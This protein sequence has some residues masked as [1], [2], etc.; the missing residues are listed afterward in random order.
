MVLFVWNIADDFLILVSSK[1]QARYIFIIDIAWI[2]LGTRVIFLFLKDNINNKFDIYC[3]VFSIVLGRLDFNIFF[4]E[5][6]LRQRLTTPSSQH[7]HTKHFSSSRRCAKHWMHFKLTTYSPAKL[8]KSTLS[9][10]SAIRGTF[11]TKRLSTSAL[12][13]IQLYVC[14]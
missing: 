14:S 12:N 5:R 13:S 7:L 3:C 1:Q 11:V 8:R 6:I 2:K 10:K 4:K 9:H